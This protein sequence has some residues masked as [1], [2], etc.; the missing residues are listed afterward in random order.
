AGETHTVM[1][2]HAGR[3][4]PKLVVGGKKLS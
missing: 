3:G 1:I 4:A 2:N